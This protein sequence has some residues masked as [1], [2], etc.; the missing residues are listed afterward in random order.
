MKVVSCRHR[1]RI[2]AQFRRKRMYD[3]AVA[4]TSAR[5][6]SAILRRISYACIMHLYNVD[7]DHAMHVC[8]RCTA[9][10]HGIS[11]STETPAMLEEI[12]QHLIK[13]V[14]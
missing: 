6:A 10:T 12:F 1:L 8:H 4:V 2:Q 5:A 9:R 11:H 13:L 14:Q 7:A 3:F